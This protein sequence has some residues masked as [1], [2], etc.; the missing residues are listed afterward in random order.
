M[1]TDDDSHLFVDEVDLLV[2]VTTT[3][4]SVAILLSEEDFEDEELPRD[5]HVKPWTI[6]TTLTSGVAEE[7]AGYLGVSAE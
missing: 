7:A 2:D 5:S 6:V 1:D 4:R 3:R